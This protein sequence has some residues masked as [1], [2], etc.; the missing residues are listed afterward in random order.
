MANQ[1][2]TAKNNVQGSSPLYRFGA[3]PNTRAAISQKVRIFTPTEGNSNTMNQIGVLG[4]FT[5]S[6]SRNVEPI[7]GIGFGDRIAELVPNVQEP[8]TVNWERALLYLSNIYQSM[9]YKGGVEGS[10]RTLAH[11]RWPF[12]VRE[13]LVFSELVESD[14]TGSANTEAST[15]NDISATSKRQAL[16]TVYEACWINSCSRSIQ[17]DQSMIMESG[18]FTVTDVHAGAAHKLDYHE[19][20][21]GGGNSSLS[22]RYQTATS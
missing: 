10:V 8:I 1:D 6:Q 17:K 5:V 13:E 22:Q 4:Q 11:H 9:G 18:D 14:V 20:F 21:E 16:I 7:R 15:Y 2:Q 12:D 3:T 19:F